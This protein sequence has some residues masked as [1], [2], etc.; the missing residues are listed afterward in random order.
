DDDALE[1]LVRVVLHEDAVVEGARLALVGVDAEIDR[2]VVLLRRRQEGPLDAAREAGAAAAAQ[3]G[4]LDGVDDLGARHLVDRPRQGPVA[5]VG[6]VAFQRLAV[7]PADA[8]Q[9]DG[10]EFGHETL[11]PHQGMYSSR[12]IHSSASEAYQ[13]RTRASA[14]SASGR[15]VRMRN[16]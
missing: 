3:A 16:T 15:A 7:G 8:A 4:L 12:S 14:T 6:A 2:A 11:N 13:I 1:H 9:K 10:F 5:A